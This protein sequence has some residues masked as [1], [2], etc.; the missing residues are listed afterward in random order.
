VETLNSAEVS[1]LGFELGCISGA[2]PLPL[3]LQPRQPGQPLPSVLDGLRDCALR[4]LYG[5]G[6]ILF[7][8]FRVDGV[9]D[10]RALAGSFGSPLL[11]YDFGSTPRSKV[12]DGV[13][14]STEYP[15]HQAIPLHNEQAYCRD[16]P[17]KVWF[18]CAIEC[19]DRGETPIADSRAIYRE[20]SP[21]IRTRFADKGL[22]YVRNFGNGLDVPWEQVFNTRDRREVEAYCS[23]HHISCEW[24]DDGELR[25]RQKCQ[26]VATHPRTRESV[27][28]NQAHL[29]HISNLDAEV[30]EALVD[31]VGVEDLPRNVYYG[32]GQPI[33][34][35]ILDEVRGVLREREVT[36]RW[37]T[38]DILLLDNMLSAHGRRPFSGP[39]KIVVAMTES[40]SFDASSTV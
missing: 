19:A 2:G 1:T 18:Y 31:S 5:A 23:T 11:G 38:G 9:D 10:F 14:S 17:M 33:E 12:S 40:Y 28:F 16:W 21:S 35:A 22:L 36:F 13:Y 25:T 30:R 20:I 4:N 29:F 24:K 7:R 39:R 37:Q 15:A 32:D 3:V 8:G 27:W 34:D 26:A 6:A